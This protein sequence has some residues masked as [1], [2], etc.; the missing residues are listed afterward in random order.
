MKLFFGILFGF[1]IISALFLGIIY[2]SYSIDAETPEINAATQYCLNA[3]GITE[4]DWKTAVITRT[5]KTDMDKKYLW[6]VFSDLSLWKDWHGLWLNDISWKQ[7]DSWQPGNKFNE[8]L[9]LGFPLGRKIFNQEIIMAVNDEDETRIAWTSD[10]YG[11][12]SCHAWYF[13]RQNGGRSF[14]INTAV[15]SGMPIGYSKPFV[16]P[17]WLKMFQD[18]L[19]GLVRESAVRM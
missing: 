4:T 2:Y 7:G 14:V 12:K 13:A 15:Y 11:I 17:T 1:A 16:V 10:Q 19:Q 5:A 3:I 18:D 8:S 6:R 9:D